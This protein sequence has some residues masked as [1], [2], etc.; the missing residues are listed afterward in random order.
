MFSA[1][2][3]LI[4]P[5]SNGSINQYDQLYNSNRVFNWTFHIDRKKIWQRVQKLEDP[6]TWSGGNQF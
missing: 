5:V 6:M 1:Q 3:G 2:Y 4:P